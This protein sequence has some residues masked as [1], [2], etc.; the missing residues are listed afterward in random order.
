MKQNI[1]ERAVRWICVGMFIF[2]LLGIYLA[3]PG[4][5][6]TVWHLSKSGDIDG[7]ADYIRSF[8]NGALLGSF[9]SVVFINIIGLP[10]IFILMV[11]GIVFGIGEGIAISWLSE[12]VGVTIGFWLL[13]VF[14]RN[15]AERIIA[16]SSRL[17]KLDGYSN[18]MTM[19][20]ARAL[21]YSPNGVITAL[22]AVSCISYRNYIIATLIGKLPS[23]AIE[24]WLG[25]YLILYRYDAGKI[26]GLIFL[27]AIMYG[28]YLHRQKIKQFMMRL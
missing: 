4:F 20:I 25:Y 24:V 28:M 13:R 12:V 9:L 8:G 7:T 5:Y 14:L 15:K 16:K 18:M 6:G 19:I 10:S 17:R 26:L 27:L 2:L 3:F 22:G 23:V 1:T 11:N 21:P